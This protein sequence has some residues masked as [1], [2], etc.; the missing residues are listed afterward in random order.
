MAPPMPGGVFMSGSPAAKVLTAPLL[1][2]TRRT[3]PVL[4]SVTYNAPSGPIVLPEP[5]VP[6][7]PGA[8]KV[9]S[10]VTAGACGCHLLAAA[11]GNAIVSAAIITTAILDAC[12]EP[13]T[14]SFVVGGNA[15]LR[16]RGSRVAGICGAAVPVSDPP[17]DRAGKSTAQSEHGSRRAR[18]RLQFGALALVRPR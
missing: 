14:A 16:H 17:P 13:M 12:L 5:H 6:V 2:S 11:D 4:P 8:A 18:S 10:S 3:R 1:V 7:H 9:T 15:A